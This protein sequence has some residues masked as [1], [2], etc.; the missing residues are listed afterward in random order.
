MLRICKGSRRAKN[1]RGQ[2][3]AGGALKEQS[4]GKSKPILWLAVVVSA[5]VGWWGYGQNTVAEERNRQ[6]LVLERE[7][8][9]LEIR[10]A[11]LEDEK[12]ELRTQVDDLEQKV[13]TLTNKAQELI[14]AARRLEDEPRRFEDENWRD[15]VPD[16]GAGVEDV[17]SA[18]DDME[19]ELP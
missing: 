4:G 17:T 3:L 9:E 19:M 13:E 8:G 12:Q 2:W 18:A 10:V 6:V 5:S 15:V 11:E 16:V 14:D 1:G 7:R